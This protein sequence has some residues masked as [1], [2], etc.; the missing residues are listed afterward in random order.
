MAKIRQRTAYIAGDALGAAAVFD[1]IDDK[2]DFHFMS[3]ISG[4]SHIPSLFIT[5]KVNVGDTLKVP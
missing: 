5:Q 3:M 4:L 2:D 1:I